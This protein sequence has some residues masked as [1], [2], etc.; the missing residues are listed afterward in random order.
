[1]IEMEDGQ[2]KLT[3]TQRKVAEIAKEITG[4][5]VSISER[6]SQDEIMG[7]IIN[8]VQA[9]ITSVIP[10]KIPAPVVS[11]LKGKKLNKQQTDIL[12]SIA[13]KVIAY[14]GMQK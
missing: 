11:F 2:P 10:F 6:H 14:S 9:L 12:L 7:V 13:A 8:N 4:E 1:M 5:A 3:E